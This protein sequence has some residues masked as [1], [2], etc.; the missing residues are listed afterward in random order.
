MAESCL[1]L[2][3]D[4]S[5]PLSNNMDQEIVPAI[6]RALLH[7]K[8]PAHIWI[9]STKRNAKCEMIAI[10]HLNAPAE[11]PLQ[12]RDIIIM[13]LMMVDIVVID[14][15]EN[16]S[17]ERLK[18]HTVTLRQYMGKGTQGLQKMQEEFE[19]HNEGIVITTKVRWLANH[20]NIKERWQNREIAASSVVFILQQS[21][22]SQSIVKKGIKAAG[23]W[24]H[25]EMYT[26]HRPVSR[27]EIA[28]SHSA[29]EIRKIE[30]CRAA[31]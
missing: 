9:M 6:N 14:V 22:M 27:G 24:D 31:L 26:N 5:I 25:L 12:Y 30:T 13:A 2:R 17:S 3:R 11:M 20:R 10:T 23:L 1:L 16:E 8:T 21:K 15:E 19:A 4:E 28:I 29:D 7:P 18:I